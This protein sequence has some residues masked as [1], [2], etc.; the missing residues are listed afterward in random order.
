MISL[1]DAPIGPGN[2][3]LKLLQADG[4]PLTPSVA[5]HRSCLISPLPNGTSKAVLLDVVRGHGATGDVS[6]FQHIGGLVRFPTADAAKAAGERAALLQLLVL[7]EKVKLRAVDE[8]IVLY[9][10][11][12]SIRDHVLPDPVY[13]NYRLK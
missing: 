6:I 9:G 7:G 3:N 2:A 5:A 10:E 8:K 13:R 1:Q 12:T 4:K 11:P